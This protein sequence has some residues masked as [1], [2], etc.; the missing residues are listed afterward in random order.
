[1]GHLVALRV[2]IDRPVLQLRAMVPGC[3]NHVS[4]WVDKCHENLRKAG[5]QSLGEEQVPIYLH[6][7][8]RLLL[9]IS[10]DRFK[11]AGPAENLDQGWA[12]LRKRIEIGPVDRELDNPE[13]NT[14]H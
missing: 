6:T 11:I 13:Y 1:M 14:V 8:L 5:F 4:M 7:K 3:T 2:G 9:M 12:L 10:G